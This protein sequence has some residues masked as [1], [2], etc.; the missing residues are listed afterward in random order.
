MTNKQKSCFKKL[1]KN[2][3]NITYYS[4]NSDL[5]KT[6]YIQFVNSDLNNHEYYIIENIVFPNCIYIRANENTHILF[7]NCSFHKNIM[8]KSL[9]DVSFENNRYYGDANYPTLPIFF[10][11]GNA[12]TLKFI[13][14]TFANNCPNL[15]NYQNIFGLDISTVFLIIDNSLVDIDSEDNKLNISSKETLIFNS[16][17][18]CP[19]I[20]IKSDDVYIMASSI[21]ASNTI[22]IENKNVE[23]S[24][25]SGIK[26]PVFIYNG[27]QIEKD[28]VYTK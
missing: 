8:V 23:N 27:E 4:S 6:R 16:T 21:M 14:E 10:F 20:N 11:T 2:K 9:G 13:N 28:K 26:S 3:N 17:I 15:E 12:K 22:S 7:K 5:G 1:K 24:E 19:D 18:N 25:I